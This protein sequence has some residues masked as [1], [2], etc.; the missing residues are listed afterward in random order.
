MDVIGAPLG[1][2]VTGSWLSH[3]VLHVPSHTLLRL[4][5]VSLW[6]G[7]SALMIA[8][9]ALMRLRKDTILR[10][11]SIAEV[12]EIWQEFELRCYDADALLRAMF[13]EWE[14][15]DMGKGAHKTIA[16]FRAKHTRAV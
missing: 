10:A 4:L 7:S 16:S 14:A 11:S 15:L 12:K 2:I 13:W 6:M 1:A 9:L 8:V 3:F 5:D